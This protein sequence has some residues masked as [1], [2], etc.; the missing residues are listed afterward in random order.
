MKVSSVHSAV[1]L[2]Q[3][4]VQIPSENPSGSVASNGEE[5]IA[6]FVG[7]FLGSAGARVEYEEI[8]PGRPNVY[9]MWP[10]PSGATKR[11]LFAP[12]LD[13]VTVE[14]MN[15]DP[16][17]AKRLDGRLYGRGSSD[18]KG[19]M[20]AMLWALKSVDLSKLDIAVGFAGL[21]D[22]EFEQLGAR[23]C[24]VRNMADFAVVGEPTNLDVVYTHKGTAWLEIETRGKAVHASI[25]E[26]GVNA[27]DCMRDTLTILI[28]RFPEICPVPPDPILGKA[29]LS[30]GRIR[31]GSKI[32]VVPDRCSAELDIRT[33]PGQ[34]SMATAIA[35]F[36]QQHQ[37]PGIVNPIKVSAPLYTSPD[38]PFIRKFVALGSRLMGANWFCDAAFFVREGMPAI[39]IGPGSIAQAHTADEFIEIAELERGAKFFTDYLLSFDHDRIKT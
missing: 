19:S 24:A 37:L 8:A 10:I 7:E 15:V 16:F 6:Q 1:E 17:L 33:L 11:I 26:T 28:E 25:P 22:E 5:A 21:A 2:C 13:T 39:A 31:G 36:L 4:L 29:T 12:H 14:G 27:I 23:A 30:T 38:N 34:E 18:T 9:G 35:E 32:N 3:A 20:A